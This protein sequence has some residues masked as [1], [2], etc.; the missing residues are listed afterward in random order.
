M[1][2]KGKELLRRLKTVVSKSDVISLVYTFTDDIVGG[3]PDDQ[4][5]AGLPHHASNLICMFGGSKLIEEVIP[6]F[7]K[8]YP[9]VHVYKSY[10][11]EVKNAD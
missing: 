5:A 9:K 6:Q 8:E 4:V 2:D 11:F 1:T 3:S 7:A 10:V